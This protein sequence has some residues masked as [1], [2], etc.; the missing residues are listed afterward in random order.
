[1]GRPKLK[2]GCVPDASGYGWCRECERALG[3]KVWKNLSQEKKEYDR[4]VDP[5]GSEEFDRCEIAGD[6]CCSCHINP[7][8]SFCMAKE[9]GVNQLEARDEG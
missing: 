4:M 3:I 2:C 6:G 5:N 9:L 7:P 1:M 8:C